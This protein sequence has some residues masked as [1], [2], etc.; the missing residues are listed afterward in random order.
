MAS[1]R[2]RRD[3]GLEVDRA[4]HRTS[5]YV[6]GNITVLGALFAVDPHA[7]ETGSGAIAVA[8]TAVATFIA[9]IGAD[10]VSDRV[11]P[12][13]VPSTPRGEIVG[14]LRDAT[15]I[16]TSGSIPVL[17]LVLGALG[18]LPA[19]LALWIGI[20]VVVVRLASTGIVTERISGRRPSATALWGG[21]VLAAISVVV[22]VGKAVLTH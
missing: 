18:V 2:H 22:A 3:G 20:G 4:R 7:V 19:Q 9:H 1:I 8:A 15:P 6:Y 17:V 11:R 21:I 14:E 16:A 13:H 5:A 12:D 10:L